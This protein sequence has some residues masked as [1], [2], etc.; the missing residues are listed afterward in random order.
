M[1]PNRLKAKLER[2]G[3][4][5]NAR[6]PYLNCG[7]CGAFA[8]FVCMALNELGIAAEPA[9]LN[10][11]DIEDLRKGIAD[12]DVYRIVEGGWLGHIAVRI[13]CQ[14]EVW[15]YDSDGV[16]EESYG[17]HEE[18]ISCEELGMLVEQDEIWNP[19][20]DRAEI[21]DVANLIFKQ[22]K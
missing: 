9:I 3:S 17:W 21:P 16:K 1:H 11:G 6:H 4:R 13:R 12:Q 15:I 5:A 8:Y 14:G 2:L 22:L 7:G 20:F 10:C 18:S 19:W